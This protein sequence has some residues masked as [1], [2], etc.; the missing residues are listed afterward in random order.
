MTEFDNGGRIFE[1][2]I[3]TSRTMAE[4]A[5]CRAHAV[6]LAAVKA[7]IAASFCMDERSDPLEIDTG[8]G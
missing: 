3:R 1:L 8:L 5:E 6:S 7:P 2:T 4:C